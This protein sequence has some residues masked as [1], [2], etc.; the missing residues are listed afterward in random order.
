ML[1]G[2]HQIMGGVHQQLAVPVEII[3][4][5]VNGKGRHQDIAAVA[6][7]VS[8]QLPSGP[9]FAIDDGLNDLLGEGSEGENFPVFR[10]DQA[11]QNGGQLG[12]TN[13]AVGAEGAID[14]I[15]GQNACPVEGGDRGPVG[16][17]RAVIREGVNLIHIGKLP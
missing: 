16:V 3:L 7:A 1:Q 13:V 14:V 9:A 17:L 15:A 12:T 8:L 5:A 10:P 4:P 11:N 2:L 6:V